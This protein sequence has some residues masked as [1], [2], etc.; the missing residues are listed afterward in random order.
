MNPVTV[1]YLPPIPESPTQMRVIYAE[2]ERTLTIMNDLNLPFMFIEADQAIYTKLLDAM[3]KLESEGKEISSKLI[4]R[5]G[6]FHV[7]MCMLKTIFSLF[8]NIGF[9]QLLN[10]AGLGGMGTITKFLKGGDVKEGIELHKKLFEAL[11]RTKL[12]KMFV[13]ESTRLD[14][15]IEL[16]LDTLI[17]KVSPLTAEGAQEKVLVFLDNKI[18]G[19]EGDMG[20]LI[21]IYLEMVNLMLNFIH[22]TRRGNWEG[23]ME[24]IFEFL[25]YCFRLNRNKYA[26]DLSFYYNHMCS[27]KT[28]NP[29]AYAYLNDGGFSGSLTG[30]PHSRIP[31]DQ[32]IEMTIN[33]SC[34]DIGGLSQT[35][36][37]AGATERWTRTNHL[38]VAL[39]EHLNKKVRRQ[40]KF[41]NRELGKA[42]I[43]RDEY[44]VRCIQDCL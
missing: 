38:M 31:F 33:R 32:I 41:S 13:N 35:T 7:L 15:E 37:N 9:V 1:G 39:R 24:A 29:A 19:A 21:D 11:M 18:C 12:D 10:S 20:K 22:F 4:P 8:K 44:N 5:M 14:D 36:S 6:G 40:S 23:F 25:P 3:F 30:L 16:E 28:E 34:K 42:K 17:E 26:R 43:K 2:V 27:L